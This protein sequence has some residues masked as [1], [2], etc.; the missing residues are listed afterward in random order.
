MLFLPSP[1]L[2]Y[3]ESQYSIH[4]IYLICILEICVIPYQTYDELVMLIKHDHL[5][6]MKHAIY[7]SHCLKYLW[8]N[9]EV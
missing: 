8:Q 7:F 6:D 1:R 3:F 4:G 9:R 5:R 2:K